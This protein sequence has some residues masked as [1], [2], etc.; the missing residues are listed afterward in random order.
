MKK[1]KVILLN[2]VIIEG[3]LKEETKT[4]ITVVVNKPYY[5]KHYV[6]NAFVATKDVCN[7]GI[8]KLQYLNDN[9]VL[10]FQKQTTT[11][12]IMHRVIDRVVA[13]K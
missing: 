2:G 7:N 3:V 12:T 9:S 1:V 6:D 11:A 5:T 10:T 13:A 4:D 8:Q